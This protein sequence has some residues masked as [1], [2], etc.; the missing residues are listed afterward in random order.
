ML[1]QL[2]PRTLLRK[3]LR[4]D[5]ALPHATFIPCIDDAC[6]RAHGANGDVIYIKYDI[7]GTSTRY[8][9]TCAHCEAAWHQDSTGRRVRIR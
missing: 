7:S 3:H 9:Y 5:P 2:M 6:A 8:A 4:H 1:E